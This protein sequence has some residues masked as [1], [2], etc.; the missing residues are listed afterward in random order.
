[1]FRIDFANFQFVHSDQNLVSTHFTSSYTQD[2]FYLV[3]DRLDSLVSDRASA[4]IAKGHGFK[5]WL[6]HTK[7][8]KTGTSTS[9]A[10][11]SALK[12]E[13]W[14]LF[15]RTLVTMDTIRNEASKFKNDGCLLASA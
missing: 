7:D 5:P 10:W 9:L 11:R 15:S 1:M 6:R 4:S 13:N 8:V 12:G 3:D 14:L 2:Q